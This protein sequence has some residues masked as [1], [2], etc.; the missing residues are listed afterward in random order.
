[1]IADLQEQLKERIK[2]E[3]AMAVK[4]DEERGA[5]ARTKES[6]KKLNSN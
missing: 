1:M 5:H 3:T 2:H 6:V 4:L